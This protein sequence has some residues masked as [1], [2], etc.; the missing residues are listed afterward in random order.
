VKVLKNLGTMKLFSK[1][2]LRKAL[3]VAQFSLSLIFILT[4]IVIYNQ[5]FHDFKTTTSRQFRW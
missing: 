4:V 1:M 2:G 3:L 5:D